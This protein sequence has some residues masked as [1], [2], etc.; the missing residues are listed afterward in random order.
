MLNDLRRVARSDSVRGHVAGDDGAG[1]D[2]G[3]PANANGGQN[4]SPSPDPAI[5]LDRHG[6]P[7]L[8]LRPD[9]PDAIAELV[10]LREDPHARPHQEHVVP[11]CDAALATEV[12]VVPDPRAVAD[13]DAHAGPGENTGTHQHGAAHDGDVTAQSDALERNPSIKTS[14]PMRSPGPAVTCRPWRIATRRPT[15]TKPVARA[16]RRRTIR[17]RNASRARR[18]DTS[19]RSS[20]ARRRPRCGTQDRP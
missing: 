1:T 18:H 13:R 20:V 17:P 4:R 14:S 9:R 12:A 16:K 11:D 19:T 8:A 10:V 2:H 3:A 6:R 5:R 15:S 7:D